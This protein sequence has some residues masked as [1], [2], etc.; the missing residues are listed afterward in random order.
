M[1]GSSEY[2]KSPEG[3]QSALR[4]VGAWFRQLWAL[5]ELWHQRAHQRKQ[6]LKLDKFQLKDIGISAADANREGRKPFWK[7]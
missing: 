7:D 4:D 1:S 3:Q 2:I 6:L 5:L